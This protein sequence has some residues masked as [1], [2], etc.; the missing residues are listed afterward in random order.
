M[1]RQAIE[2]VTFDLDNTL[3]SIDEVIQEAERDMR[4]WLASTVP[5]FNEAFPQKALLH[6]REQLRITQPEVQHDVSAMRIAILN[7]ALQQFGQ[8]QASAAEI[9]EEAFK[10]FMEGRHRV[11]Y[12]DGVETMLQT[13]KRSYVLGTL[14]N[15]NADV[16]RL[17]INQHFSFSYSSASVG[18]S[19]P[20]PA[21]FEAA[22]RH[23]GV[24]P[25]QAVHIGDHP[26][27]DIQGAKAVG[28]RTIWLDL[29]G[30]QG[31]LAAE[32]CQ[33]VTAIEQIVAAIQEMG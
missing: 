13:L 25:R 17:S 6:L 33:R 3:W 18:A 15:G 14:T 12:F 24:A 31:E 23:T 2:L 1:T 30:T 16:S 7:Q 29:N 28:M 8:S 22:L 19:K 20:H 5:G 26:T 21:M 32:P 11:R 9:A 10:I 27:D 4:D